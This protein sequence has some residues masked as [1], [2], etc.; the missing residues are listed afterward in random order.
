M[1]DLTENEVAEANALSIY[2]VTEIKENENGV[3][4]TN[5]DVKSPELILATEQRSDDSLTFRN[6][7]K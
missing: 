3:K 2:T 7:C 1:C 4:Y 5:V 6:G